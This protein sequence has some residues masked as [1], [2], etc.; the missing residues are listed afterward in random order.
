MIIACW[1]GLKLRNLDTLQVI[2]FGNALYVLLYKIENIA[3]KSPRISWNFGCHHQVVYMYGKR[4]DRR[5]QWW[6]SKLKII[7]I[8][9]E[10]QS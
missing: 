4:K 8:T 5:N 2:T 10:N 6:Q 3:E 1:K 9:N 7:D